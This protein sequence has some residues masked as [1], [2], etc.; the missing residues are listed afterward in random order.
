MSLAPK[1]PLLLDAIDE[2]Q[3]EILSDSFTISEVDD[4]VYEVNCP[5]VPRSSYTAGEEDE[6]D[7]EKSK[8]SNAVINY[9]KLDHINM[10]RHTYVTNM[11]NYAAHVRNCLASQGSSQQE[12]SNFKRNFQAY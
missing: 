7:E 12:I 8:S 5:M 11:K 10:D 3:S 1:P 2:I 6:N 4:I 9:F